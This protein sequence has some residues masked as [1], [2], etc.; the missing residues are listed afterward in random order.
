MQLGPGLGLTTLRSPVA[1]PSL[2]AVTGI[3]YQNVWDFAY[4]TPAAVPDQLHP[5]DGTLAFTLGAN[6]LAAQPVEGVGD[7]GQPVLTNGLWLTAPGLTLD[8][9]NTGWLFVCDFAGGSSNVLA[10]ANGYM[11]VG[12]N[13]NSARVNDF[14]NGSGIGATGLNIP[15]PVNQQHVLLMRSAGGSTYLF[16]NGRGNATGSVPQAGTRTAV[17]VPATFAGRLRLAV[18]Y[19][20]S[21]NGALSNAQIFGLTQAGTAYL[22][23]RAVRR[24]LWDGNSQASSLGLRHDQSTPYRLGVALGAGYGV[25]T[26]AVPSST[27]AEMTTLA[28]YR[29][30]PF[31]RP[32]ATLEALVALESTNSLAGGRTAAQ[33]FSDWQAYW[34]AAAWSGSNAVRIQLDCDPWRTDVDISTAAGTLNGLLAAEF[35]VAT[36]N[37]RV[38]RRKVGGTFPADRL[39]KVSAQSLLATANAGGK[40]GDGIHWTAALTDAVAVDVA[41]AVAD[42][43]AVGA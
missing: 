39:V 3:T 34:A 8:A 6:A 9:S 14:G 18:R 1:A 28:P 26:V 19:S 15:A 41:A 43:V 36:S 33:A 23:S 4:G 32:A 37:A 30:A 38:F 7:D 17:G 12:A 11:Y 10:H 27:I 22:M 31:L 25:S 20:V 29:V 13:G 16:A 42:Y 21:G 35:D 24:A 2:L 5:T 40:A